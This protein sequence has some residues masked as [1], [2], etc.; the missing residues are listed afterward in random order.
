MKKHA[1]HIQIIGWLGTIMLMGAYAMNSLGLIISTG[2]LY[3]GI[4]IL[5]GIF[6]GIRVFADRNWSN[7][8]LEFFW[9]LIAVITLVRYF[10]F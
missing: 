10:L 5:A 1:K 3:A 7:L 8:I 2:P 9:V 4:N 6:L